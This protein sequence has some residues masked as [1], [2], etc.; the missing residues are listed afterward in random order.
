MYLD[1]KQVA[2]LVTM[3]DVIAATEAAYRG[4]SDGSVSCPPKV[5][6]P[7][8]GGG[9]E[10]HWINSMPALW[11]DEGI[12]GI[13]WSNVTGANRG[14][15]LPGTM[16][17]IILN[18]ATTGAPLAI[19]EADGITR[20][21]AGAQLAV[22]AK[23]LAR[24]DAGRVAVIGAGERART[25]LH[26]YSRVRRVSDVSVCSRSKASAR[27][28]SLEMSSL[29]DADFRL[30]DTPLEACEN[31]DSVLIATTAKEVVVPFAAAAP[32]RFFGGLSALRD[33]DPDFID[34]SDKYLVDERAGALK[35][36]REFQGLA[37]EPARLHADMCEVVSGRAAGRENRREIITLTPT[38]LGAADVKV[39]LVAY[40]RMLGRSRRALGPARSPR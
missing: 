27:A 32:G 22:G 3:D 10:D 26:A 18:D 24:E 36:I 33:L 9:G 11:R 35:R 21:R 6:M 23:Y 15:G 8:P 39:A 17:T 29:I 40:R 14:R 34:G 30:C 38:G 19:L 12:A 31:A 25:A 1:A 13:K 4:M 2:S 37:I 20:E 28:F 7:L 5:S 16:A